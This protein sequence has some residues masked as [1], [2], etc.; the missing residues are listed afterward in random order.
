MGEIVHRTLSSQPQILDQN[1]NRAIAEVLAAT[2][3]AEMKPRDLEFSIRN[4]EFATKRKSFAEMAEYS[5]PRGNTNVV[6]PSI[7]LAEELCKCFGNIQY[8]INELNRTSEETLYEVYCWDI[9]N[10]L[11]VS[12]RFTQEHVRFKKVKGQKVREVLDDS[13]DIYEIVA[14]HAARR[15]RAVILEVLPSWY[16]E[17]ARAACRKTLEGDKT[18]MSERINKVITLFAEIGVTEEMIEKKMNKEIKD[19]IVADILSLGKI[20]NSIS[21]GMASTKDHFK[22]EIKEEKKDDSLSGNLTK[23]E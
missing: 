10:N 18:P 17:E 19:L 5:Y 2:K 12:R 1:S 22:I 4:M 9:E 14:N 21:T 6:G 8:G 3:L 15:L 16:V 13:R 7:R 20:Y 23:S 11:R